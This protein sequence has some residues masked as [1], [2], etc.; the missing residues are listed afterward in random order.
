M[1]DKNT[2]AEYEALVHRIYSTILQNTPGAR[3]AI[4]EK[5]MGADGPRQV[6]VAIYHT[7]AG[8][9]YLT[10]IECR[11]FATRIDI[12]HV[13]GFCSKLADIKASKGIMVARNGYSRNALQKA[14]R[15]GITLL[16]ADQ[17]NQIKLD[18]YQVIPVIL[19]RINIEA[20]GPCFRLGPSIPNSLTIKTDMPINGIPAAEILLSAYRRNLVSDPKDDAE[21]AA[22]AGQFDSK[23]KMYNALIDLDRFFGDAPVWVEDSSGQKHIVKNARLL[24]KLKFNWHFGQ[25]SDIKSA[26]QLVDAQ[27]NMTQIVFD[28]REIIELPAS[29]VS[30]RSPDEAPAYAADYGL[31]VTLIDI[32]EPF[33]EAT[34]EVYR[35]S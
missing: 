28:V 29:L 34:L 31:H 12:K 14:T 9:E 13:D 25:I 17:A 26:L 33:T 1:V 16:V 11:D 7:I 23:L 10:A 6:D 18:D 5:I 2:G 8:V 24:L 21:I 4:N 20:V 27:R 30:L 35:S 32:S 3:V 22:I 15:V 19:C